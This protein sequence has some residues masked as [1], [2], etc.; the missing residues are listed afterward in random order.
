[1]TT[2][3]SSSVQ[4]STTTNGSIPAP[5]DTTTSPHSSWNRDGKIIGILL[6]VLALGLS[7]VM[8][9]VVVVKR[10]RERKLLHFPQASCVRP[11]E[12]VMPMVARLAGRGNLPRR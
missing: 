4:S 8:V 12:S 3:S 10:R 5:T 2:T 7:F 6:G 11:L 1:M 9:L